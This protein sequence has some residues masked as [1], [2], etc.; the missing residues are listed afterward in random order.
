MS[1]L[2]NNNQVA[3]GNNNAGGLARWDAVTDANS[4][5]FIMPRFKGSRNRGVKRVRQ[6]GTQG[7]IGKDSG[8]WVFRFVTIAQYDVLKDTYEGLITA[9]LPLEVATY[10]NY[11][12]VM[13]VPDEEELEFRPSVTS[14]QWGSAPWPAYGPVEVIVR[15]LEA[16]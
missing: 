4:I 9:K 3:A 11:N 7:I 1:A 14:K 15:K 5:K 8:I 2:V 6:N 16:L 10:A 12:A 13:V